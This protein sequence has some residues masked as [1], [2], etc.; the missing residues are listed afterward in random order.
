MNGDLRQDAVLAEMV[1]RV[2][3]LIADLSRYERLGP[4]DLIM[5]GTPAGVGAVVPGDRLEGRIDGLAPVTLSV[6]PAD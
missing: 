4:G 3:E 1:W 5:T 6:G 2:P